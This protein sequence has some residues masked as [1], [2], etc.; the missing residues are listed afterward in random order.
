MSRLSFILITLFF[1]LLCGVGAYWGMGKFQLL[2]DP[3]VVVETSSHTSVLEQV[4][5]VYKMV[6]VEAEFADIIDK[7]E[8]KQYM[9]FTLPY[10]SKSALVKVLG[11]VSIGF[12]WEK[13]E[14]RT[15][16]VKKQI[17]V[18]HMPEPEIMSIDTDISYYDLKE[19]IFNTFS[20]EDLTKINRAAKDSIAADAKRSGLMDRAK[21]R[22]DEMMKMVF[23]IARL[24]GWEV[25]YK[26]NEEGDVAPTDSYIKESATDENSGGKP[27]SSNPKQNQPTI[28]NA[29]PVFGAPNSRMSSEKSTKAKSSK[30]K[31][32]DKE[33]EV[34][35]RPMVSPETG[36]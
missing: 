5:Q 8:S 34:R 12:D 15:D 29:G 7:K 2:P 9:G 6:V 24:E 10:T 11:K 30:Q 22:S 13:I 17:Y 3:P 18:E 33:V 16:S 1:G 36:R 32:T 19:G 28:T 35:D 26:T 31:A 27:T 20:A 21:K 23:Q 14:L 25:V 4:R